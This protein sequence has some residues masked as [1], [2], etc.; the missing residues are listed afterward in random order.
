M[1]SLSH[2]L[3]HSTNAEHL[4]AFLHSVRSWKPELSETPLLS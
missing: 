4:G 3:I 1:I 2:L